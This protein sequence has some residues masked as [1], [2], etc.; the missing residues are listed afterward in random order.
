MSGSPQGGW[1]LQ[2][3]ER[4]DRELFT[5]PVDSKFIS[6]WRNFE[7]RF[8][9]ALLKVRSNA[10]EAGEPHYLSSDWYEHPPRWED[11][12]SKAA[13]VAELM[14]EMFNGNIVEALN[15]FIKHSLADGDTTEAPVK[16]DRVPINTDALPEKTRKVSELIFSF[17]NELVRQVHLCEDEDRKSELNN[18]LV[19]L[20]QFGI[21]DGGVPIEDVVKW[22]RAD[23]KSL[24]D[25]VGFDLRGVFRRRA[26]VP[27][28]LFPRHVAA[29][30]RQSEKRS[31]YEN[32]R[33]AHEAFVF[34][35]PFAALALMRSIMEVVLRDHY[36]AQG[37][38]RERINN[39]RNLLPST[40]NASALHRLRAIVNSVLHQDAKRD[41]V[42]P[43][44][45]PIQQLEAE[46]I[47]QLRVLRA[48]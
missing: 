18:I 12:D 2:K 38:D 46:I 8:A 43:K 35:A 24:K 41:E 26:L 7:K 45:E 48:H 3:N 40:A 4:S 47:S 14:E 5:T 44:L 17:R 20:T 21:D 10:V 13:G 42:L 36:G 19:G 27:F 11:A 16:E 22:A 29:N 37:A 23:W 9:P 25:E 39:S 28:V 30:H 31:V 34:G 6:T 15:N 1:N 33:Q 32:L